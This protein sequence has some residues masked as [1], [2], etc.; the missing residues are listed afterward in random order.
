MS[1]Q[2]EIV[3]TDDDTTTTSPQVLRTKSQVYS[4]VTGAYLSTIDRDNPPP[5]ETIET[6][7]L[8]E[9][10]LAFT[11]ENANKT[12]K[13]LKW[14]IPDK[15]TNSQIADIII[16]LYPVYSIACAGGSTDSDY[17]LLAIYQEH[18]ENQGIYCTEE[19][20]F[21]K[22]ARKLNYNLSKKDFEEVLLA[23]R[24]KTTRKYRCCDKNLIAMNNGIYDYEKKILLP[25]S[26][27][28]VFLSKSKVDYNP[29]AVNITIHNDDDGTDWDIESWMNELSD[30]PEV[31][32]LLW[33]ILGA[34]IRPNVRWNKSAWFYSD[35]G[36][37]GKGTLCT[38]MR[39]LC[40]E[41]SYASIQLSSFS[42]DFALEPLTH[43][44]AIIV[45]ENDVG[46]Y[47]DK[48]ANLKAIITNDVI[49]INR[50]YKNPIAYQFYGFMVQCLNEFP[51]IK[52]KSDSFYRRQIFIPFNKCFTGVERRYIK[53]DYLNRTEV[54]E[55]VAYKVLHE[56][57]VY[58]E[59]KEPA[60]CKQILD[61]YKEFNDPVRQFFEEFSSVFTWDLLP[62]NFLY[63]LYKSWF[64]VNSPSGAIQ[65]RNT[66]IQDILNVTKDD[67]DWYC[68]DKSQV[69]RSAGKMDNPEPLIATY[70]LDSWKNPNYNGYDV[71][72]MC[73]PMLQQFY[74]GLQRTLPNTQTVKPD[75]N[76]PF[77]DD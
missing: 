54:L 47:I 15:L 6:E 49:S 74:R 64:K 69:I 3:V 65:G 17:D 58:Y 37:N 10:I 77:T 13:S 46:T 44:T 16:H 38:L 43:S 5:L 22:I 67:P 12:D 34:I 30:D 31:V 75:N 57:P 55:Y 52:D 21:R 28:F 59:L 18:G 60:S 50:K 26:P 2:A 35:K 66:F 8:T 62:F 39:N 71:N 45:D 68:S 56:I 48:A 72:Q 70:H 63:E 20:V 4:E 7:L 33:Q 51:R 41:G 9:T 61:E 14:A 23:L 19:K 25:F 11:M 53:D 29:A 40:G 42:K 73:K 76:Q 24:D 36:N 27:D 32:E 1:E